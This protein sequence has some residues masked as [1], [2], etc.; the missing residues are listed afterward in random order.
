[1]LAFTYLWFKLY[2]S[3]DQQITV[4][5]IPVSYSYFRLHGS[6]LGLILVTAGSACETTAD[7]GDT[8]NRIRDYRYSLMRWSFH[9]LTMA[10]SDKAVSRIKRIERQAQRLILNNRIP[11]T[12]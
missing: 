10:N 3:L 8:P 9:Y 1:M 11:D 2:G 6:Y 5:V 7:A 4:F 12:K